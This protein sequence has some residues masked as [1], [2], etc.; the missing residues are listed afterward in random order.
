[1]AKEKK[2]TKKA[3]AKVFKL[4]EKINP[5]AS[6]LTTYDEAYE[7]IFTEY[8]L[9]GAMLADVKGDVTFNVYRGEDPISIATYKFP[10]GYA[11]GDF[12]WNTIYKEVL[13]NIISRRLYKKP[14]LGKRAQKLYDKKVE[15]MK[16][17]IK[18]Q[19]IKEAKEL[20]E[21]CK[22][23][24]TLP[25]DMDDLKRLKGNLKVKIY[26]WKKKNKDVSELEN[27]LKLVEDKIQ[28]MKNINKAKI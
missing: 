8:D 28:S 7:I 24:K 23:T 22:P 10:K 11:E 14:K 12:D 4:V 5:K 19:E 20:E 3:S 21:A 6:K 2:L 1:M 27:E 13:E 9:E 25:S 17:I 26:T 18:E 16:T 15:E